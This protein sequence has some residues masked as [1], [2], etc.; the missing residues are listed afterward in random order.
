[1][2]TIKTTPDKHPLKAH[3]LAPDIVFSEG[4]P[5]VLLTNNYAPS[6]SNGFRG[7]NPPHFAQLDVETGEI[8]DDS[9]DYSNAIIDRFKLQ[10]I[11]RKILKEKIGKPHRIQ[12]CLSTLKPFA[13]GVDLMRTPD[14]LSCHLKNLIVC[15]RVWVCPL[16]NAKI[17]AYRATEIRAVIEKAIE[18]GYQVALNT[19]TV[20]NGFDDN[21][22]ELLDKMAKAF[23]RTWQSKSIKR[24]KKDI[25]MLGYVRALETTFGNVNG[26]HPHF[27]QLII[28]KSDLD[29]PDVLFGQIKRSL[30]P[31]W[32][33]R[34]EKLGLGT[35]SYS[36]G[37][38]VRD[39]QAAAEYLVNFGKEQK[40]GLDK[41]LTKGN[42]KRSSDPE[43]FTPFDLARAYNETGKKYY[44]DKFIEYSDAFYGRKFV[45]WSRGLKD[46][47]GLNDEKTD[48]DVA[49]S[50][51][52]TLILSGKISIPD[53]KKVLYHRKRHDIKLLGVKEFSVVQAYIDNLKRPYYRRN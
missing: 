15:G 1:M 42:S 13:D 35:P 36:H 10:E 2:T 25:D 49:E 34:C 52:E 33:N 7:T 44:A 43:K 22:N 3:N 38:D 23:N 45:T 32:K 47:F 19:F 12:G 29:T 50:I 24:L 5:L 17:S 40:W 41:E 8:L 20:P 26:F 30:Y 46:M 16:C 51:D 4:M 31:I 37:L 21:L 9:F 14:L 39:G 27:H 6:G 11:I 53:W 28:Y 18:L 48:E